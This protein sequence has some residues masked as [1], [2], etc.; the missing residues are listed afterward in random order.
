MERVSMSCKYH[1]DGKDIIGIKN[2]LK[3]LVWLANL[4]NFNLPFRRPG[5][6]NLV[7]LM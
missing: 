1:V 2:A 4:L 3:N 7:A 5:T 6:R